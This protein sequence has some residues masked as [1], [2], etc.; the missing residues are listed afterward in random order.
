MF[1][2]RICPKSAPRGDVHF[3][4][5]LYPIPGAAIVRLTTDWT[6]THIHFQIFSGPIQALRVRTRE[7][8]CSYCVAGDCSD[9]RGTASSSPE[10]SSRFIGKPL[11]TFGSDALDVSMREHPRPSNGDV[12][13]NG[14]IRINRPLTNK[15]VNHYRSIPAGF[16]SPILAPSH[17]RGAAGSRPSRLPGM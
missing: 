8:T 12:H 4:P 15:T 7:R 1:W 6:A 5:M 17:P 9:A 14:T 10:M 13:A 11:R 2:H 16:R 3:G